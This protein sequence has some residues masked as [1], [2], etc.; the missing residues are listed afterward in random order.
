ML[1]GNREFN[2]IYEKYKNLVLKAA[3]IYSGDNYDAA[4][5]ITQDTFLKL[6]TGFEILKSGNIPAW[7]YTT[8]KNSA[9][10]YKKKHKREMLTDDSN[11]LM[12]EDEV[13]ESAEEA[14]MENNLSSEKTELHK[15]ILAGL[16]EKNPR[17][18]EAVIL[19][20]YMECPQ[21]KAAE[22]MG[23]SIGV[24]HSMLHRAKK[25]IR[26]TYGAEYEEM[27]QTQ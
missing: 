17:W 8:A 2:E 22:M 14:Y 11:I 3:Y 13:S 16:M 5:D 1:T 10:N 9:M 6:Y 19:V 27:K 7:L 21:A 15:R 4:E 26:K 25:W 20:Y 18:Y 23:V 24:L 12:K